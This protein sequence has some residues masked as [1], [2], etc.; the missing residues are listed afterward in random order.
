MRRLF[1]FGAA[2]AA[3]GSGAVPLLPAHGSQPARTAAVCDGT[4]PREVADTARLA[5]GAGVGAAD[6]GAIALLG[7]ADERVVPPDRGH[8]LVRHV[9]ARQGVGTAYVRDRAGGDVVVA[10]TAGGVRRFPTTGE[11]MHPSWSSRGDL[12]WAEGGGLR[13]VRPDATGARV[14]AGPVARGLA[15]SPAFEPD[16][17]IATAVAAPPITAVP[18]DEYLSNLWRYDP[19]TGRWTRLTRFHAGSDRWSIVRTPVVTD[20]GSIEFVRVSGH[21]SADTPPVY[22]LWELRGGSAR[23]LRVLPGEMYLAGRD[24]TTRLWNLLDGASGAWRIARERADGTLEDVGCGAVMVDPLDRPDPDA[25]TGTRLATVSA[26]G[27]G[28]GVAPSPETASA[29]DAILVG[30]FSSDE[31]AATAV[32]RV[33]DAFGLD[34][35]VIDAAQQPAIVRPGVWAVLVPLPPG[36]DGIQALARFRLQ[37]PEFSGWSWVVSV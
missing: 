32:T 29:V 4:R 7:F 30:D 3:L 5:A 35:T 37:V 15:F 9:A 22:A 14:I 21:A 17:A 1:L 34:A 16:G 20:H 13:L 36:T 28:A 24:G 31:D 11:A 25:R 2:L 33:E 23:P 27:G 19:A 12:V 6:H 10:I 8:G 26:A 18:E